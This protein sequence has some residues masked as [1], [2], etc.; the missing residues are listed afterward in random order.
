MMECR[1][2]GYRD[3]AMLVNDKICGYD[4]TKNGQYPFKNQPSSLPLFHNSI[5]EE[6]VQA[7]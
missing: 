5:F 1:N 6:S 7:S 3:N 4:K 2:N